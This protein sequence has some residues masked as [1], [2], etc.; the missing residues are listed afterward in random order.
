MMVVFN[1]I[2]LTILCGVAYGVFL[3][4]WVGVLYLFRVKHK[5]RPA[6]FSIPTFLVLL[7]SLYLY[8]SRPSAT[9]EGVLGFPPSS[10]VTSLQTSLFFLGDSGVAYLRFKAS[11][12]TIQWIVARG[13]TP[14]V[15]GTR[16]PATTSGKP[17]SWWRPPTAPTA[18]YLGNFE[19]RS[20]TREE[21]YLIYDPV[22]GEAYFRFLG[23]D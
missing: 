10:D 4:A 14:I 9:F 12:A 18:A 3:A 20:F 11:P 23:V 22:T 15:A 17:P 19:E 16:G 1:V 5:R 7:V 13:L 21:E 8:V 2:F 6:L